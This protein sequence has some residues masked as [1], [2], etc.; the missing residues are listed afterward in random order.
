V[1]GRAVVAEFDRGKMAYDAE[2]LLPGATNGAVRLVERFAG[3]AQNATSRPS[4]V[5]E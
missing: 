1:A 5:I 3:R 2:T 4:F